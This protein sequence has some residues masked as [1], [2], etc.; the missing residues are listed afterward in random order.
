MDT[1]KKS[2]HARWILLVFFIVTLAVAA[3]VVYDSY[4]KK[5]AFVQW[6]PI[7]LTSE[8]LPSYLSQ[9]SVIDDF[10]NEGVVNLRLGD[11]S[12]V[13]EKGSVREG[14]SNRADLTITL[15]AGYFEIL[16]KTGWCAGIQRARANGEI[17]IEVSEAGSS[18]ALKYAKLAKY[19]TCIG[20]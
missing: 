6:V 13:I 12:Y 20:A 9:F 8:N 15:P 17:G 3:Y 19:R 2:H 5:P 18:L 14:T 10:P 1:P 4:F 16:G 11:A 7:E